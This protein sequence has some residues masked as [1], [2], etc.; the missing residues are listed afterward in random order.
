[1]KGRPRRPHHVLIGA[2]GLVKKVRLT[3]GANTRTTRV[4]VL[5]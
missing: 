5:R 2:D 1:M 4:A 3:Q